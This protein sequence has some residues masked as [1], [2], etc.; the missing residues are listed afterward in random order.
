MAVTLYFIARTSR[1]FSFSR[2][3][4]YLSRP[5]S[6]HPVPLSSN[7]TQRY[8][9]V[10]ETC[11]SYTVRTG[12]TW[13]YV[14]TIDRLRIHEGQYEFGNQIG[15]PGMGLTKMFEGKGA[16]KSS[17]FHWAPS[18][19]N[20]DVQALTSYSAFMPVV[21][22]LD[23][24]D[25]PEAPLILTTGHDRVCYTTGHDHVKH[26]MRHDRQLNYWVN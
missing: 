14:D 5:P 3:T 25:R 6:I 13:D 19:P 17:I 2:W 18:I 4:S 24:P 15:D 12:Q 21:F 8:Q 1:A 23:R 26:T 7:F 16:S 11:V 9:R 20:P 22:E 10:K